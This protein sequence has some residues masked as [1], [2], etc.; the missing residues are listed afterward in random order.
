M[1]FSI[2]LSN[3][4]AKIKLVYI[5]PST[6][7]GRAFIDVTATVRKLRDLIAELLPAHTLSGC[8]T[9]LMCHGMGKSKMLKAVKA[10]KYSLSLL[11]EVNTDMEDVINQATVFMCKGYSMSNTASMTEARIKVWTERIG[12]KA[13]SKVPKLCFLPPTTEAFLLNVRR[14]HFQCAIWR[15]ALMHEPPNLYLAEYGWFKDE[16]TKS[17]QLVMLLPTKLPAP[18]YILKLVCC[19]CSSAQ[20]C[21]SSR[22]G[23]VA[24]NLACTTFCH[25]QEVLF[26]TM[27]K[28]E[29]LRK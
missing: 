22:C 29:L 3:I 5:I 13:A 11:G 12:R 25:C 19:S 15:R 10:K 23:C 17:L 2:Q 27:N 6:Q 8:D 26:V 16:V 24:A 1:L 28:L 21:H 18:D 20:P 7:A 4:W 9:V 14:A